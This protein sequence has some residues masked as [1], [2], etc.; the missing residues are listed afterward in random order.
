M[1]SF[2]WDSVAVE[3][4]RTMW[5]D[6]NNSAADIGRTL[7]VSRNAVIGKAHRIGLPLRPVVEKP[8]KLPIEKMKGV[9]SSGSVATPRADRPALRQDVP[10]PALR[11]DGSPV[12]LETVDVGQCRWPLES[13]AHGQLC[14]HPVT[15]GGYCAVH[16]A[17][18]YEPK[19]VRG[20]LDR[21]LGIPKGAA[22]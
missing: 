7:G 3:R 2:N 11:P 20:A 5:M 17:A 15:R 19:A 6:A 10:S 13:G 1:S 18:A 4:L 21:K 8:P 12:T 16:A 14:G 22:A 9:E